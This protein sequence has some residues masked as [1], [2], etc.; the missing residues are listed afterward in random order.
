MP[1][2]V[3]A[4]GIAPKLNSFALNPV[5]RISRPLNPLGSDGNFGKQITR[6]CS[7]HHI[8]LVSWISSVEL[9]PSLATLL[10]TLEFLYKIPGSSGFQKENVL[11]YKK[12]KKDLHQQFLLQH[13]HKFQQAMFHRDSWLL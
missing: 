7:Q 8:N 3:Q 6:S 10:A 13:R 11:L 4:T 5:A 1:Q 12:N 2:T 9:I